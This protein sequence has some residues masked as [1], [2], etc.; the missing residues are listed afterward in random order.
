MILD[1]FRWLGWLPAKQNKLKPSD[2]PKITDPFAVIPM[3]PDCVETKYD[4]K[5]NM[6]LRLNAEPKGSVG[7]FARIM[8]YDYT[9]KLELDRFGT[10]YYNCIDGETDLESIIQRM[11]KTFGRKRRHMEKGVILFT[12]KLMTMNFIALKIPEQAMAETE[13]NQ[14]SMPVK[15]KKTK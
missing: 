12:R 13:Q 9:K 14:Q 6:H 8:G 7:K 15:K 1:F 2:V 4:S 5:G 10:E 11:C 3:K